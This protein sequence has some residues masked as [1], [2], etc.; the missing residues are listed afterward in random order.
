MVVIA[1]GQLPVVLHKQMDEYI[2]M[3]KE[4]V[5][6]VWWDAR[7]TDGYAVGGSLRRAP[8]HR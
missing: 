2:C 5:W 4:G 8:L 3:T 1:L 6:G 7:E